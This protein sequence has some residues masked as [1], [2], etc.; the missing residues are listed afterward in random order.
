MRIALKAGDS[1]WV[2][3]L[4]TTVTEVA[5]RITKHCP[6]LGVW[7]TCGE[8]GATHEPPLD[9][10]LLD[11]QSA[12][13]TMHTHFLKYNTHNTHT[14]ENHEKKDKGNGCVGC[15]VTSQPVTSVL[16]RDITI[17]KL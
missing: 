9:I 2:C 8:S 15:A 11:D 14:Q 12:R 13:H 10:E 1:P 7:H 17:N 6:R 5:T 4:L 16:Q 3:R